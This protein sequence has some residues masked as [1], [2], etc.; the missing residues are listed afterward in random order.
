VSLILDTG[1]LIA[2]ERRDRVVRAY[3]ERAE[4]IETPVL[5]TTA[6]VAQAW[7]DPARQALLARLLR[8][9]DEVELSQP[10]A[11]AIGLLLRASATSDVVDAS[12]VDVAEDGD[13]ILT[14]DPD[15][16]TPLAIAAGKTLIVTPVG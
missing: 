8:G 7:R 5:T 12:V 6:V 4:R 11:R 16:I 15:D 14:A 9:V 10:R 3:L 2:Y 1:A 13:E